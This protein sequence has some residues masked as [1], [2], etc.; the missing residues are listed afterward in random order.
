MKNKILIVGGA[1]YIGGPLTDV[2][3]DDDFEVTIYDNLLYEDRYLK[4][5]NF[6]FGDVRDKN[7]LGK[8]I[9]NY[10]SVIWLAGIVGD[11]ACAIHKETTQQ[12]NFDS[13]KWLV[14]NYEGKIIFTST[15]SIYGVNN[16]LIN[17]SAEPNPLS[18]Y[19]SSKLEAER[20]IVENHKDYTIFRLGTLF[21]LGDAFSRI[22][23]DLVV[24]ALVY[25]GLSEKLLPINGGEQWRPLLHVK[26]V[27]QAT[28]F[29]LKNNICGLYNLGYKNFRIKDIA[30]E[31]ASYIQDVEIKFTDIPFE[32]L[33]NYKILND[34]ILNA[35]WTP[36]YSLQDGIE[37][38]HLVISQGRI[39]NLLNTVY[40]NEKHLRA[41]YREIRLNDVQ[42]SGYI[43]KAF[44]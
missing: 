21:G 38:M 35:G 7:K 6:I 16:N 1:G 25:K 33:R 9:H 12:V 37:E 42:N 36:K 8:I 3:L 39:K 43:N 4:E 24:N 19:A 5:V 28:K 15:C 18:L 32:D 14:D 31:I 29:C 40:S 11:Q 2:L 26:D 30:S 27:A 20:Y 22:R 10:D 41:A 13:V 17:E 44:Y 34:K 23:L